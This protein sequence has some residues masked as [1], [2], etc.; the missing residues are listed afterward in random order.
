M[1]L[2][3]H[4]GACCIIGALIGFVLGV[5]LIVYVLSPLLRIIVNA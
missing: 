1:N 3:N 5:P 4:L 2:N